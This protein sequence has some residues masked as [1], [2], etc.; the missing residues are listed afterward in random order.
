[1]SEKLEPWS[2]A[3]ESAIVIYEVTDSPVGLITERHLNWEG[4]SNVHLN[5]RLPHLAVVHSNGEAARESNKSE[6]S[7][8]LFDRHAPCVWEAPTEELVDDRAEEDERAGLTVVR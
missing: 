7:V 6:C 5:Q 8:F 2:K 4:V 1:M 3:S